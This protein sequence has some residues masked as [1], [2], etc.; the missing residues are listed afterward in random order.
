MR[1]PRSQ[2]NEVQ[3]PTQGAKYS[4]AIVDANGIFSDDTS[5]HISLEILVSFQITVVECKNASVHVSLTSKNW[6]KFEKGAGSI[7]MF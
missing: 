5:S 6:S 4:T 2:G 7:I 1:Y 3:R